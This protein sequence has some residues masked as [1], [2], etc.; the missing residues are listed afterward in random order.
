MLIHCQAD[1]ELELRKLSTRG[2]VLIYSNTKFSAIGNKEMYGPQL[3]ELAFRSRNR[4]CLLSGREFVRK[5]LLVFSL[6][7]FHF[8]DSVIQQ[9]NQVLRDILI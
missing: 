5:R 1:R 2:C 6:C 4:S 8:Y 7:C 3:G 9:G